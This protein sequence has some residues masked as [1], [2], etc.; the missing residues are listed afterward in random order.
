[1]SRVLACFALALSPCVTHAQSLQEA[2]AHAYHSNP[3]LLGEQ[4]NQRAVTENSVQARSGWRPTV[5]VNMDANYQQGPYTNAFA[6]GSYTSNYA[7]GY[8]AAKQ[9]LYSF[10]HT[11]NQVK[12]AD[13]RSH[14]AGHALRLTE[15]QV[16]TNVITAYMNVLRDRSI[17]DI[18]QA[19][20]SMLQRQVQ[21]TTSRYNL[22]GAPSEQVTRTDVEQ[23]ETRRQ[24]AEVA[25][26]QARATLAASEAQFRAVIG[27]D[28][29]H[30]VM[31]AALPGLPFS[32]P[33]AM[34]TAI[35]SNPQL[36]QMRETKSATQADVETARSQWGPQIQVQ[37]TFGTIGPG[38]P[39]RGRE[40]GE[41]VT[42]TVSLVQP[43]YNGGLYNSQIRQAR[44]KDEQAH[45]NVEQA[46]RSAL[47]DVVT[48]W[49]A[50]ENGLQAIRA[51]QAEVRSGETTL[52]GYQLEY[53]YGLRSTTDVLYAD[54]NLRSAQVE[55]ATSQHDT[56]VAQAQLLA[57]IGHLQAQD[58]IPN[59]QSYDA[60][61]QL[62]HARTRDWEPLQA[63]LAALDRAGW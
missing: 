34:K 22:G 52:K 61:A 31:P 63:P 47:Q 59:V 43:I 35:Q 28:P 12:A 48:Y 5:S 24:S 38:A 2:L 60:D 56:I 44:D 40:Y 27:E 36:A 50:V 13:A 62:R 39:F 42:G 23:A 8:V 3:A 15:A 41:Q 16:F 14:A 57:A 26:T 53:G 20:L 58:L 29:T 37:G 17:K 54:Q 7:E 1:M 32:M 10:G 4:A 30:L 25:L 6:L 46:R 55:L 45:Q 21:L 11:A 18:R 49:N 9:T 19:D 33:Q 51:G